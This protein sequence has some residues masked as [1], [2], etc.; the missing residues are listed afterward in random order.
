MSKRSREKDRQLTRL[1]LLRKIYR[2]LL[3]SGRTYAAFTAKERTLVES[4]A[5]HS[6][7]LDPMAGYGSVTKYCAELGIRSYCVEYNLPQYLW[8]VLCHPANTRI[9]VAAANH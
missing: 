7:I 9:I 3:N 6:E 4:L 8:Q 2:V 1:T 5:I